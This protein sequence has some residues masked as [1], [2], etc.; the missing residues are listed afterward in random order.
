MKNTK[1]VTGRR[2]VKF[3]SLEEAVSDAERVTAGP[4]ETLGNWDAAQNLDHLAIPIEWAVDGYPAGFKVPLPLK[5]L[6]PLL[7]GRF[8]SKGFPAG[9]KPDENT[10]KLFAPREGVTLDQALPRLKAAVEKFRANQT[11][12]KNP[13]IGKLN[14]A[15]WEQFMCRHCELH[16][17][18][19]L[20]QGAANA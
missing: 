19:L 5:L 11:I 6:G 16:L 1:K 7:A 18:F 13:L 17:S 15:Q 20:P 9:I 8:L 4:H 14:K 2:S 10:A 3:D 12:P